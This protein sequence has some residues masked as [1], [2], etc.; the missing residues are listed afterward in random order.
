MSILNF[1]KVSVGYGGPPLLDAIDLKINQGERICLIGRNGVGKSTLLKLLNGELALE[2]GIIEAKQMLKVARLS[3]DVDTS[4]SANVYDV[5]ASGLGDTGDILMQY[6]HVSH[7][8]AEEYSEECLEKLSELQQIID[9]QDAW[10]NHTQITSVISKLSLDADAE[11]AS[12]SGGMKRRVLLAKALVT[13]PDLLLLDEPTNHLDIEAIIWLENFL[14]S[15]GK[16]LL[17]ITHDRQFLQKLATRIIELDRGKLTSWECDYAT[18]LERKQAALETEARQNAVFDKKLAKE[19]VWVRQGIKA[20]RTRN[21]G[22]VRALEKIRQERKE[23]RA[24]MGTAKLQSQIQALSGKIVIEAEKLNYAIADKVIIKDFSTTILRGDK[25]AIIGPNGCGKTTLLNLLLDKLKASSGELKLGTNL[26]IAYFDQMRD[27]LNVEA[28]VIDNVAEGQSTITINGK[29]KHIISYLQDFLFAPERARFPVKSLSGG[30][31]NRLLLAKLFTKPANLLVLDEPTNDLDVETL[32]L[33]ESLIVDYK[34]TLLLVSHDREFIN[35]VVSSTIV[36]EGNAK[37]N[38]YVGDYNDWL[39]QRKMDEK[40][41]TS[42]KSETT[43]KTDRKV[44]VSKLNYKEQR[45]LEKLPKLIGTLEKE[46]A[47]LHIIMAKP[48]FYQ[49]DQAEITK[50]TK[51]LEQCEADLA[52]CYQR[53][54]QLEG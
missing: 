29:D 8:L 36:Y 15:Y 2:S 35:N 6:Q 25:I 21:E 39:W 34:G 13:E 38:E 33:L 31:K 7:Q 46:I 48:D 11:F 18:Y 4:V 40:S 14:L 12:L 22:R 19:E 26:E 37:F 41:S 23:R 43:K 10:R 32:E 42:A 54:E 47:E 45:E 53:W 52:H 30:E 1:N 24:L 44:S 27:Q 16:T 49:K 3:Q 5:V 28:S 9:S 50:I 20:R 51:H 17:F